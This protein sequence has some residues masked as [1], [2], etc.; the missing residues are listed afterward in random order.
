MW[1]VAGL[2]IDLDANA[3]EKGTRQAKDFQDAVDDVES[4]T[5]RL[6]RVAGA[7]LGTL[8]AAFSV[9]ALAQYA[10]AW[11]DMQSRVGA[12]VKDMEA[13]PALMQRMVQIANASYSP[14]NQTV[15]TYAQNVTVLQELGYTADQAADYTESLNH[16]LVITA[17]KGERAASVQGAL[18]KAMA[19]GKL[20]AD[21]LETVLANGGRVAEALAKQ[22]GTTVNGLRGMASEGKITSQVISETLVGSLEEVRE[23]AGKM[24]ATIADGF[25][26]IQTGIQAFVGQLD[27][28]MQASGSFANILVSIGDGIAAIAMVDFGT[29]LNSITDGVVL[30]GQALLVLAATRIPA[31]IA[32]L[33]ATNFGL[34]LMTLQFTAG[35]AASRLMTVAM[36]AQAAAARGLGAALS[37]VGGPIGLA[38]AAMAAVGVAAWN[39]RRSYEQWEEASEATAAAQIKLNEAMQAFV[40]MKSID[41]VGAAMQAARDQVAVI[42]AEIALLEESLANTERW[43]TIL[44]LGL[45]TSKS[46][47]MRAQLEALKGDLVGALAVLD[48]IEMEWGNIQTKTAEEKAGVI[49]LTAEQQK[50]LETANEML[51][52]SQDRARLAQL[53][54][55]FGKDSIAY[56]AELYRQERATL[57][58]KLATLDVTEDVK[59]AIRR[60][61]Q[62]EQI[63]TGKSREWEAQMEILRRTGQKALE[64]IQSISDTEPGSSWLDTAISKASALWGVL[65]QAAA[66][67]AALAPLTLDDAGNPTDF[68]PGDRGTRPPPGRPMDLGVPDGGGGG[69]G[70]GRSLQDELQE[71]F[72]ALQQAYR[73]EYELTA[74]KYQDDLE[75]LKWALDNKKITYEAYQEY[76]NQLRINTWASEWEQTQLQYQM[77]QE[78]LQAA[79][80]Q[81]LI[82]FETYYQRLKELQWNNLLSEDNRSDMAQDLSN[83][84][85]YF[86]QL[87]SLTGSSF[88][89]LLR[90]QQGFQAAAALM[91]AWKG[92][93]DAL[94][95]GGMTPWMKLMWA[96]KI[97][98]AGL[99]AVRAIKG[100]GG[101]AG[102][103]GGG[104]YG[105]RDKSGTTAATQETAAPREVIVRGIKPTDLFTGQQLMDLT[106]AVL[107]EQDRRGAIIKYAE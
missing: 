1:D 59:N 98:A 13:A 57:E 27:Q 15:E 93:T 50:A 80:D 9:R 72:E 63:A 56:A 100:G 88:D 58:T 37:F 49:A 14:L 17:T 54:R 33:A 19:L 43:E 67:Y 36:T 62:E 94:A 22:L 71:R 87:Y 66:E 28:A 5:I 26:R 64:I 90:L 105:G 85:D 107:G 89:A 55:D 86:S 24:P 29:V 76:L 79:L 2:K 41:T 65:K 30:L 96:G 6:A 25:T 77:D 42:E 46:D 69:G 32:S 102:G 70:G 101:G 35:A 106:D 53:E 92:Y 10:D 68:K 74:I 95:Q 31:L 104:S 40:D 21:G 73:S 81:K 8:A 45:D 12:A 3:F 18:S 38:V 52:S 82:T 99:G 7:A 34:G 60:A 20:Q 103:G 44:T 51:R 11:S 91:N 39:T 16:M 61:W 75:A 48:M 47:E 97:L 83:T 4:A 78:A 23:Q 84:A